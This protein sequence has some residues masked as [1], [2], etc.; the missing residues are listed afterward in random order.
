[1]KFMTGERLHVQLLLDLVVNQ[2]L[3]YR[4]LGLPWEYKQ[5]D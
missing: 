4:K 2:A 1:M 3:E 5:T